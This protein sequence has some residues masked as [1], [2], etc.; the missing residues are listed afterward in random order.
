M[1]FPMLEIRVLGQ[2]GI[3]RE[4][5]IDISAAIR[6][7]QPLITRQGGG[8]GHFLRAPIEIDADAIWREHHE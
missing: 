8:H 6:L 4:G 5:V 7:D 2:A 3:K 1:V